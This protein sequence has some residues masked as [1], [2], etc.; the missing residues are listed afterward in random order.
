MASS[1]SKLVPKRGRGRRGG[2]EASGEGRVEVGDPTFFVEGG[3]AEPGGAAEPVVIA[4]AAILPARD[5]AGPV[6]EK[7]RTGKKDRTGEKDKQGRPGQE[8]TEAVVEKDKKGGTGDGPSEGPSQAKPAAVE[9]QREG[10]S[11][12]STYKTPSSQHFEEISQGRS[13]SP[14]RPRE[15]PVMADSNGEKSDKPPQFDGED[16]LT[17]AFLFEQ[18]A[19][20][21]DFWVYFEGSKPRPADAGAE[22]RAWDRANQKAFAK[23]CTCMNNQELVDLLKPFQGTTQFGQASTSGGVRPV[24]GRTPPRT[25]EAWQALEGQFVQRTLISR[26]QQL[27]ELMQLVMGEEESIKDYWAR[28][29]KTWEM[30]KAAGGEY[31]EQAWMMQVVVGLPSGY[32]TLKVTLNTSFATLTKEALLARLKEEELRQRLQTERLGGANWAASKGK[33]KGQ[34]QGKGKHHQH[35]QQEQGWGKRGKAPNGQCHGCWKPGHP[36]TKCPSRPEG[37]VPDFLQS[38]NSKPKWK[39]RRGGAKQAEGEP[40][41][42]GSRQGEANY[43]D[44]SLGEATAAGQP[45]HKDGWWMDSGATHNFTPYRADPAIRTLF[46]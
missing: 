40:L 37:A 21:N 18:W 35:Q 19:L 42:S 20:A 33:G 34:G 45:L 30:Y 15:Q 7:D 27:R 46:L 3:S 6:K 10:S 41:A 9:V 8:T 36:W 24:T 1:R 44:V 23:L 25:A 22:Q 2:S 4:E 29:K 32:E 28:A 38:E 5:L 31:S 17:W 11:S 39:P 13:G 16:Y 43:A 12:S 26:T 14:V